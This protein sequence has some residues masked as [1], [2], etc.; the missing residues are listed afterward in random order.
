[1]VEVPSR[2]TRPNTR[3]ALLALILIATALSFCLIAGGTQCTADH[4]PDWCGS[5][6]AALGVLFVLLLCALDN[7]RITRHN[8]RI[9]AAR[10]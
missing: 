7:L 6:S 2:N 5:L 4:S 3:K 8:A 9:W 1:M 10:Q